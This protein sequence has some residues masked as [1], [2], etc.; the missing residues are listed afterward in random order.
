[1]ISY[2]VIIVICLFIIQE[3][4]EKEKKKINQIKENKRKIK[5]NNRLLKY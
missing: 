5:S 2:N 1:M 4:K 3:I